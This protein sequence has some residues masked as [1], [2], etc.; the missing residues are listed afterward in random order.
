MNTD[1]YYD[2]IVRARHITDEA[3][4]NG[5]KPQI[6]LIKLNAIGFAAL[7][8]SGVPFNVE[9]IDHGEEKKIKGAMSLIFEEVPDE[10][11]KETLICINHGDEVYKCKDT[12]LKSVMHEDYDRLVLKLTIDNEITNPDNKAAI[13]VSKL[14]LDLDLD[15]SDLIRPEPDTEI[16]VETPQEEVKSEP[17]FHL[18]KFNHDDTLP[19]DA[20]GVK[21]DATFLCDEYN[22][23]VEDKTNTENELH[24]FIYPLNKSDNALITDVFVVAEFNGAVRAGISKGSTLAVTIDFGYIAFIAKGSWKEYEFYSQ[25]NFTHT[26]LE[27][28]ASPVRHRPTKHTSTTYVRNMVGDVALYI[29][30]GQFKDNNLNGFCTSAVA[31][32]FGKD[33]NIY[34]P[35]Q[36]GNFILP[37]EGGSSLVIDTYWTGDDF[38]YDMYESQ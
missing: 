34:S 33:T 9:T 23:L 2:S 6:E 28:E 12:D 36:D 24:V 16:K 1:I 22:I 3:A 21:A 4:K 26:S 8:R 20:E 18:P 37:G 15:V 5:I 30:P 19:D 17:T 11:D 29:F 35:N 32:D 13:D 31:V 10:N 27:R 7:I 25:I 14:N 38:C